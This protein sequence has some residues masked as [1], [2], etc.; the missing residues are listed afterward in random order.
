MYTHI[1]ERITEKIIILTWHHI[2]LGNVKYILL[3]QQVH[4]LPACHP[5]SD[6]S[7]S[8]NKITNKKSHL[9]CMWDNSPFIWPISHS[10]IPHYSRPIKDLVY[11]VFPHDIGIHW[12]LYTKH[13]ENFSSYTF[14]RPLSSILPL[15]VYSLS[16]YMQGGT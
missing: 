14:R 3:Y 10:T 15:L 11:K 12:R 2:I 5:F 8:T 6:L 16:I 4:Q 7:T 13:C 1:S 9:C